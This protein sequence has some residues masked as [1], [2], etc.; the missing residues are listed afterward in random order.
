MEILRSKE[1]V[2]SPSYYDAWVRW[3][4]GQN[5]IGV[6]PFKEGVLSCSKFF[7]DASHMGTRAAYARTG[8]NGSKSVDG[9]F[10]NKSKS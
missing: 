10:F 5:H 1:I 6:Q 2:F 8:S 9:P 3:P 7:F 4:I